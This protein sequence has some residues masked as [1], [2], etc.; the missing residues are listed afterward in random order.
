MPLLNC[1]NVIGRRMPGAAPN[2]HQFR[3]HVSRARK[4]PKRFQV[5]GVDE[6]RERAAEARRIMSK[7]S[8]CPRA[9]LVDR[10][11][12]RFG[13]C[14]AG[15]DPSVAAVVPH[16]GEEPPLVGRGGAGTIFFTHCNMACVYCQNHQI[17]GGLLDSPTTPA[18]L[19]RGMLKLQESGCSTL[20][21]VSPTHHL[22]GLLEALALA[23]DEGLDLP[24]VYN[25]NGYETSATLDLL[26]GVVDV[27]LPDLK[28][29]SNEAAAKFSDCPDYVEIARAAVLRMRRQ[30]GDLIV[31]TGG[32]AKRG[33]IIRHLVLPEG[34]SGAQETL[35]W[36]F[37]HVPKTVT[38]SL[39]AQYV[40]MREAFGYPPLDR[41]IT[42]R[43]YDEVLDL[44]VNLG[45]TNVFIQD[46]ASRSIGVPD[47]SRPQP[48][49]WRQCVRMN[50]SGGLQVDKDAGE[51]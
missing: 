22:A 39:M 14:G 42:E 13:W 16:F 30:V 19:A 27:Y 41:P 38:L 44:A 34:I 29:A 2:V 46:P 1:R 37:D 10:N 21:A 18:K 4:E 9:C 33:L 45:F 31:D 17:S 5:I 32:C 3:E 43:E 11:S 51:R 28:Y 12:R 8:L 35:W 26:D 36:M 7:C 40:P 47:F 6:L 50:E 23:R 24:F 15:R 48:F 25:T 20:E 49:D